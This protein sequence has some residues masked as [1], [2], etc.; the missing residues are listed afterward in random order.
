[1][2][3]EFLNYDMKKKSTGEEISKRE[4]LHY[5]ILS[6]S[7]L[8][9]EYCKQEGFG[10]C[11]TVGGYG[12]PIQQ[13]FFKYLFVS[14]SHQMPMYSKSLVQIHPEVNSD[15]LN[16]YVSKDIVPNIISP[17]HLICQNMCHEHVTNSSSLLTL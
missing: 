1:V 11:A 6:V 5:G 9:N 12:L 2:A 10:A 13:F 8:F 16:P 4:K 17:L 3:S 14:R 15:N 7:S